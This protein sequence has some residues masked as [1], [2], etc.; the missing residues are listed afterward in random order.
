MMLKILL[1]SERGLSETNSSTD[2]QNF[3]AT[4]ENLLLAREGSLYFPSFGTLPFAFISPACSHRA[5]RSVRIRANNVSAGSTSGFCARQSAVRSPRKAAARTD[6]RNWSSNA[7]IAS[8]AARA[9]RLRAVRASILA[10]MRCCS[11]R[12]GRG[13]FQS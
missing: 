3:R 11:L 2:I 9:L 12:G 8:R 13:A 7:G 5:R 1:C 6:C 10:T 4:L